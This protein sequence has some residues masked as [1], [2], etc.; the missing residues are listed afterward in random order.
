[1]GVLAAHS[2]DP[3]CT[4]ACCAPGTTKKVSTIVT[5]LAVDSSLFFIM[6][7]RRRERKLPREVLRLI[8]QF[9]AV[10]EKRVVSVPAPDAFMPRN[11]RRR[12]HQRFGGNMGGGGMATPDDLMIASLCIEDD[13][14]PL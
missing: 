2:N 14:L 3:D 9:A 13:S 1:M 12:P 10:T 8:I 5:P 11:A 7:M 4:L 6:A